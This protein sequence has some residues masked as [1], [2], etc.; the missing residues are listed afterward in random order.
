MMLRI[1]LIVTL[2]LLVCS[3]DAQ[4]G[5]HL[6]S[7]DYERVSFD[8]FAGSVQNST[9]LT[10][11]YLS[12]WTSGI[13]ITAKGSKL[14]LASILDQHLQPYGLSFHIDNSNNVFIIP[15]T[16]ISLEEG[17]QEASVSR[18]LETG[19]N[20][21]G[22]S[23]QE[24]YFGGQKEEI[25][26]T[27]TIGER[28]GSLSGSPVTLYGKIWDIQNGQS[29]IGATVYFPETKT[30]AVTDIDGR[31]R[32]VLSP[33][34]YS[35][36]I[37]CLG[38]KEK[39][40]RL[41]IYS[42]GG[43]DISMEGEII[44]INEVVIKAEKHQNVSGIQM[45]FARLDMKT[46][47]EIPLIMGEK[48]VLKVAQMLPGIQSVGEG[49][50]GFN[51]RGSSA[52][53]N[54]FYINKIPVYNT[55]H[56]FGFF[57]SFSPDIIKNFSLYKS[58]IP[59]EFGGRI[60][61]IFNISAREGNKNRLTAKGG[62]S[63][64][65]GHVAVEG[66]LKK[67]KHS[68]ILS[69]RSTYSDWIFSLLEDPGLRN[70][71]AS[72]Y[73]LSAGLNFEPDEKNLIKIFGYYTSD[74][75]HYEDFLGFDYNNSG[76]SVSWRR[77][78]SSALTS[79]MAA[80]Y[81]NY[82]FGTLNQEYLS[83]AYEH[84]Y[85]IGHY[86]IKSDFSWVPARKHVISFGGS[87]IF[88]D[89]HRGEVRP[90]GI[91]SNRR[92]VSLGNEKGVESTIYLGDKFEILP[93]LTLYGGLR[94]SI[95]NYLGPAE[96]FDYAAGTARNSENITDT[97]FYGAGSLVNTWSGPDLRA[98]VKYQTGSNSSVKL[99]YNRLRQYLFLLSNTV[100]IAP[101]DQWKLCDY[102]IRPPYGDQFS[103]GFFKDFPAGGILSS[104]E[105]YFKKVHDIVDYKDGAD[106]IA[107]PHIEEDILQGSQTAYGLELMLE[108]K[109]GRFNGWI[110]YAWSRSE[111][112]IDGIHPW[113]QINNGLSYP[114]NYDRPHALNLIL[115][116]R[117]NRRLSFSGNLVYNTG[118]PITYPVSIYYIN[119][120]EIVN[121]S[122]RNAYRLPDYFRMDLSVNLEGNLKSKKKVH[123]Y[124]M[125]NLYNLTGR[126]N[127]YT[128]YFRSEQ[129]SING[130]K[131][132]VFG[133]TIATL[134]WNFKFGNYAS[135]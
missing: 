76:A 102:H 103:A 119:G 51:V 42:D 69:T 11:Y 60:A 9:G 112:L 90:Y 25:I 10:F 73:D 20:Y 18:G 39:K 113:E 86:E 38:M 118:R 130:Y 24:I 32:M 92:P 2:G 61:S 50:S 95:F 5:D 123:S 107:S 101:T 81:G 12:E 4:P 117:I 49:S 124:W 83:S 37:N 120:Q 89:L 54:M 63:P 46:I 3:A 114:A 87:I 93:G 55:S 129:G 41:S 67:E 47:K 6:F 99:S 128:V 133:T 40:Y 13:T 17:L 35:V 21:S 1:L 48:D 28:N 111:I 91:E 58:N 80:V 98:A 108:K 30:G 22:H 109:T 66:P 31:Y 8:S 64:V 7:G 134:S 14:S 106:F 26:D 79:D 44:P 125:I 68:F 74:K 52:D 126:K 88:Y 110:S 131:I 127:A 29:L 105:V 77:R 84:D 56:L 135:E 16:I 53:Q 23:K 85:S 27:V 43:L 34:V 59:V 72:F 100:A 65:T 116:G 45:G 70:S 122:A 71:K 97:T 57:S 82:S 121:F 132:S 33:G 19:I 104:A 115:N 96:V 36:E 62:I 75:F 78:L 94:Y 15:G